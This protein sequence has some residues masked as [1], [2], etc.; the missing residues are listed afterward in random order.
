MAPRPRGENQS[1][2]VAGRPCFHIQR[3]TE[4]NIAAHTNHNNT[5]IICIYFSILFL[6]YFSLFFFRPI[7]QLQTTFDRDTPVQNTDI[8]TE[9]PQRARGMKYGYVIHISYTKQEEKTMVII[10]IGIVMCVLK[11]FFYFLRLNPL[12]LMTRSVVES[13]CELFE[14]MLNVVRSS[15][16][17][18]AA[19]T[20]RAHLYLTLLSLLS[21]AFT[22]RRG[23]AS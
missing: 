8:P 6:C 23:Y 16:V 1:R 18:S 4:L 7:E 17:G 13:F 5:E 21:L 2:L 10:C 20:G 15:C 9:R 19:C 14:V 3:P 11:S 22:R 12:L